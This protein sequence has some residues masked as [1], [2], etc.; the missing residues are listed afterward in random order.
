M[1]VFERNIRV[2]GNSGFV[3]W[4][5]TRQMYRYNC[6]DGSK[7][8]KDKPTRTRRDIKIVERALPDLHIPNMCVGIFRR[9]NRS[10]TFVQTI[11][12]RMI[13]AYHLF[14]ID[15]LVTLLFQFF[16]GRLFR[17][18]KKNQ[19]SFG[20]RKSARIKKFKH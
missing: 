17:F 12:A 15:Y 13:T 16:Q 8:I 5:F 10:S 2:Y 9:R 11:L 18:V 1:E 19:I 4:R 20:K 6:V 7:K 3:S 14:F